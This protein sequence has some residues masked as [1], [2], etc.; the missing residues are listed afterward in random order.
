MTM[1]QKANASF[2]LSSIRTVKMHNP[3]P[4]YRFE[5]PDEMLE[6]S[7]KATWEY[8]KDTVKDSACVV[9]LLVCNFPSACLPHFGGN[10]T[11]FCLL[12]HSNQVY[13]LDR[14]DGVWSEIV[15]LLQN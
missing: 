9:F 14:S 4:C 15:T 8:N 12:S 6:K 7:K 2:N 11:H 1:T 13:G 3:E 10:L 5:P